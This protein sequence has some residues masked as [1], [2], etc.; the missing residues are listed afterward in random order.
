MKEL[1]ILIGN[2][3]IACI[4]RIYADAFRQLGHQV[5]VSIS[6]RN[7]WCDKYED[8]VVDLRPGKFNTETIHQL[9]ANHDIFFLL[10]GDVHTNPFRLDYLKQLGKRIIIVFCGDDIRHYSAYEQ[11][12]GV[13]LKYSG[14]GRLGDPLNRPLQNIR[15]FEYYSDIVLSVP[16]QSSLMARPYIHCIV[17]MNINKYQYSIPERDIPVIAHA[18]SVK[19]VKGTP[20]IEA[21]L[22]R[23]Y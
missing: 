18:P 2:V 15:L 14:G 19:A 9:I 22:D 20:L 1:R 6:Q 12:Y 3:D 10:W 5:T 7:D 23:S 21:A 16:N 4:L 8:D 13:S 11:E 17:P